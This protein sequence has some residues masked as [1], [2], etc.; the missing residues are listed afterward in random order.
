MSERVVDLGARLPVRPP[1]G[2]SDFWFAQ[3]EL[4]LTRI[5]A[6]MAR[7]ERQLWLMIALGAVGLMLAVGRFGF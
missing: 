1:V 3:I 5:E 7:L 2:A 4:R 6:A